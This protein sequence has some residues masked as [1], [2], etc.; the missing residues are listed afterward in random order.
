MRRP[1]PLL[2]LALVA[3]VVSL[4]PSLVVGAAQATPEATP[5][6][7]IVASAETGDPPGRREKPLLEHIPA[8]QVTGGILL[9]AVVATIVLFLVV[10]FRGQPA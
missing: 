8:W 5:A 6:A 10:R 7:L 9:G 2:T 1:A 3:L 4:L